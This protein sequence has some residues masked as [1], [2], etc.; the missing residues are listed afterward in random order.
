MICKLLNSNRKIHASV[1]LLWHT[2][3]KYGRI[4]RY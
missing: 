2:A 3:S 4:I 1:R